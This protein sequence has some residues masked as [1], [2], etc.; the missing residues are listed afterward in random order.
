MVSEETLHVLLQNKFDRVEN[1]V[2]MNHAATLAVPSVLAAIWGVEGGLDNFRN[3]WVLSFISIGLILI[4]RSFAHYLDD[5][6]VKIYGEII[7]IENQL[8]VPSKF[9]LFNNLIDS[10]Q[11][12]RVCSEKDPDENL[13]QFIKNITPTKR[14]LFFECLLK[15]KKMGARGHD[16][17]DK[18]AIILTGFFFLVIFATFGFFSLLAGFV[19]LI[20]YLY[21]ANP[22]NFHSNPSIY[23][24]KKALEKIECPF[25]ET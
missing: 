20:S 5:D 24:L 22:E 11:S 17:W 15:D 9:S 21:I 7:K 13:F 18:I 19:I 2:Q 4:W 1:L 12:N 16:K 23:D 3:A 25:K 10:F 6:I 14:I 8:H